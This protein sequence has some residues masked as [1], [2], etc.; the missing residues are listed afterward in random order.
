VIRNV[1]A[2]RII[3]LL[4][5]LLLIIRSFKTVYLE[6]LTLHL[7][8]MAKII[9]LIYILITSCISNAQLIQNGNFEI[10][11]D[12]NSFSNWS[13]AGPGFIITRDSNT[14][15]KGR[16]VLKMEKQGKGYAV[17]SQ[18]INYTPGTQLEKF[19]FSADIKTRDVNSGFA[20]I[21]FRLFDKHGNKL[22]MRD[23]Q[24]NSVKGT[25]G[26][27]KIQFGVSIPTVTSVIEIAGLLYGEGTAWFDD[28]QLEKIKTGK[29]HQS[30][31]AKTYLDNAL[32]IITANTIRKNAV[33]LSLLKI[34]AH[35]IAAD[36]KTPRDCYA[37]IGC[38]LLNLGDRHS[39]FQTPEQAAAYEASE[40]SDVEM[41]SGK[42]ING[43]IGY[44]NIPAFKNANRVLEKKFADSAHHLI[45]LLDNKNII[46]WIVDTRSN[47]GGNAA[48]MI[49]GIGPIL[50]EGTAAYSIH[51]TGR[52]DSSGYKNGRGLGND[53]ASLQIESPYH[54]INAAPYVAVLTGSMTGSSGEALVISFKNRPRTR[55]FG[56]PTFG[57]PTGNESFTLS[58]G[59]IINVTSIIGAD[60]LGNLYAG[61]IDPDVLIENDETTSNDEVMDAA[62]KWLKANK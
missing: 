42:L 43:N 21:V 27:Q 4:D 54:L 20:S 57:V 32:N 8:L 49:I 16:Y 3:A 11:G 50:G 31:A 23:P 9:F 7:S 29:I 55:S 40:N 14:I 56:E 15:N 59:A 33:D 36:A 6:I 2:H 30:P 46:G 38:V 37:A 35:S 17:F 26:W 45:K 53:P 22:S 48:P 5:Y 13:K 51:A 41:P 10:A 18:M 62:V 60:R 12:A 28:L 61:K 24:V 52:R 47:S 34:I 25:T 39:S 58:D 19:I 44:I 1:T